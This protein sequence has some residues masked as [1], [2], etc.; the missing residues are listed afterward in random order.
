MSDKKKTSKRYTATPRTVTK[1]P[2]SKSPTSKKPEAAAPTVAASISTPPVVESSMMT[3]QTQQWIDAL[4][5]NSAEVACEAAAALGSTGVSGAVA[6]L[7]EVLVN[8]S[9]YYH[10]IV[11]AAAASSLGQLGFSAALPALIAGV[12]DPMAEAS[13]E[14]VRALA[15]LGDRNAIAPLIEVV[16]NRDG[17]F[18]PV[19]RR[20][21]I[22]A[23]I[24]LGGDRALECVQRVAQN[25]AEE[26]SVREAAMH[27]AA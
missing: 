20:A 5:D 25:P 21:A 17:F 1:K 12:R 18:L 27:P 10:S 6:P 9:G 19:V 13:A 23:L 26:P 11:R 14:A 15:I 2:A 8:A 24:K 3:S 22:L 4:K 16:D 7:S